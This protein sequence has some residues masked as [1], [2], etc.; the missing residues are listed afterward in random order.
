M[1]KDG[2]D[3]GGGE[4]VCVWGGG[5]CQGVDPGEVGRRVLSVL[6]LREGTDRMSSLFYLL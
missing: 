2:S 6:R 3:E 4:G 1:S 5:V